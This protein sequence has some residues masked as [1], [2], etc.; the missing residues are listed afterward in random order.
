MAENYHLTWNRE[1]EGWD[2]KRE[3]ASRPSDHEASRS[4][5]LKRARELAVNADV[6]L[7]IHDEDGKITG[8]ETSADLSKGIF[9]KAV[10]KIEGAA[11][12]AASVFKK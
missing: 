1:K 2:I 12:A 9:A 8:T 3:G 5:A 10:D 7:I 6:N 4:R 11:G